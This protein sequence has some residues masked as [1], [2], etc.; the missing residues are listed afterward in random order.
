M[1]YK[2]TSQQPVFNGLQPLWKDSL[3][4]SYEMLI[5]T[6][7]LWQTFTHKDSEAQIALV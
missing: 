2:I 4:K 1:L 5:S 3:P 7:A 6:P